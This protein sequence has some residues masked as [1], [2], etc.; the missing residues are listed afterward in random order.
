MGC[1]GCEPRDGD[2]R[3]LGVVA[4]SVGPTAATLDTLA[5]LIERLA[6]RQ[7]QPGALMIDFASRL[8]VRSDA[9]SDVENRLFT[10]AL[11]ASLTAV[12]VPSGPT[13]VAR[14]NSIVWV[15]DR[16]GDIPDWLLI[17]NP[18]IRHIPVTVPDRNIRAEIAPSLVKILPGARQA[19]ASV[20]VSA[21]NA[22]VD[23]TEG[24]LLSDLKAIAQLARS[25]QVD[26][27]SH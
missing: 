8:V 2:G 21:E 11:I 1:A 14:Y 15:V 6:R 20:V 4:N 19:E 27:E 3:V 18:R 13:G 24:M 10:R 5:S 26:V 9:L 12:P 17:D 22:L 7:G 23:S 25:E 16:E